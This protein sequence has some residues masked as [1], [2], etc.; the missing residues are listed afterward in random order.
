MLGVCLSVESIFSTWYSFL[1]ARGESSL[2]VDVT[3][4]D[5]NA[6]SLA[7]G[8]LYICTSVNTPK[9]TKCDLF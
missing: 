7:T 8:L 3:V 6:L 9:L 5:Q 4:S 2:Q 1:G